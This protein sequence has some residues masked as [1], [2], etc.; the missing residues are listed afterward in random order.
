M[1]RAATVLEKAFSPAYF[2]KMIQSI[3]WPC[4]TS[5][6]SM[7]FSLYHAITRRLLALELCLVPGPRVVPWSREV[8]LDI[9]WLRPSAF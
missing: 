3:S 8:V 7:Q 2:E 4:G 5:L 9:T 6:I 1:D